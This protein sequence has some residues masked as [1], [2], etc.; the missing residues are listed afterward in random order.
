MEY[1]EFLRNFYVKYNLATQ[2]PIKISSI[3][4]IWT[5]NC[6]IPPIDAELMGGCRHMR[7]RYDY[8]RLMPLPKKNFILTHYMFRVWWLHILYGMVHYFICLGAIEQVLVM[9]KNIMTLC[10]TY[11][12]CG[13]KNPPDI[14]QNSHTPAS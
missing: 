14:L 7:E 2:Y 9:A 10:Y 11:S 6:M 8:L 13:L 3:T 1:R 5:T 12:K 4:G